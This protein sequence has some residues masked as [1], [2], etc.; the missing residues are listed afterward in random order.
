MMDAALWRVSANDG[1]TQGG[2][3]QFR[4]QVPRQRIANNLAAAGIQDDGQIAKTDCDTDVSKV[5]DP[6]LSG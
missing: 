1:R 4:V 2:E 3:R 6:A 5:C